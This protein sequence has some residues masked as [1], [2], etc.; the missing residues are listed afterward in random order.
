MA[1]I[2]GTDKG[3]RAI[4]RLVFGVKGLLFGNGL[5]HKRWDYETKGISLLLHQ[6]QLAKV[7]LYIYQLET[8]PLK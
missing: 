3:G 1:A 6:R 4:K 7:S 8:F 2:Y 5:C